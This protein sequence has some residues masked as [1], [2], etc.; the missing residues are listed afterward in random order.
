[1]VAAGVA[2]VGGRGDRAASQ[3][4]LSFLSAARVTQADSPRQIE[5]Q[6][7]KK[8]ALVSHWIEHTWSVNGDECA[9]K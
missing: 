9:V 2:A 7:G 1:M 6:H 4:N 3:A 8:Y 5:L